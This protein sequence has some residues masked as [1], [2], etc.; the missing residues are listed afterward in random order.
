MATTVVTARP[1]S[2]G[3]KLRRASSNGLTP[4]IAAAGIRAQGIRVPPPTQMAA[5]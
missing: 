1:I 2:T 5:T 4:Q 3:F